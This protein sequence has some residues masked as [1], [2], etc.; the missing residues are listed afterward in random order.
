[1]IEAPSPWSLRKRLLGYSLLTALLVWACS[2]FTTYIIALHETNESFDAAMQETAGLL[3]SFAQHE[4]AETGAASEPIVEP[5]SED[6]PPYLH[7]Q[8]W[9]RDHRLL[10]RSKGAPEKPLEPNFDAGLKD[11]MVEGAE[12]RVLVANSAGN[13]LQ[14][15]IGE[16]HI[17]RHE[18]EQ[19]LLMALF[20]V[21][22]LALPVLLGLLWWTIRR[23]SQD[24]ERSSK[25]IGQRSPTEL[26]PLPMDLLPLE[27]SPLLQS[28]NR[29]LARLSN[30]LATERRFT[31]DASHELR[32]PLA[33]IK[34]QA[35]VAARAKGEEVSNALKKL[36]LGIDRATHLLEQLLT[37]ARAET[38]LT[39]SRITTNSLRSELTDLLDTYQ[40]K[41]EAKMLSLETPQ[42]DVAWTGPATLLRIVLR[43]L[44]DNAVNYSNAG[45]RI[46]IHASRE[47]NVVRL[48]VQDNG[49]GINKEN[50]QRIFDRFYR[51]PG[52]ESPGSGLG[53]AIVKDIVSMLG[54]T[55]SVSTG[56][57]GVGAT[58]TVVLPDQITTAQ[59]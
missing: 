50:E 12:W 29:L 37:S 56:L 26:A 58:F 45:G 15:Q 11:Q 23:I 48:S 55:I 42:D 57:A 24:L 30:A 25:A 40:Q 31:A 9:T 52:M 1:M 35:Q 32:T 33:A 46:V 28:L 8:V 4:Y 10:L 39:Q 18:V 19:R 49:P 34:M 41:I 5:V 51:E 17:H 3:L 47:T 27:F 14:I 54:G 21:L 38:I 43:N 44:V 22:L 53:L 36:D 7:Y 20:G 16:P 2:T 59:E 13:L 6:Y